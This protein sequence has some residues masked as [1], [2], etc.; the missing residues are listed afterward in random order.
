LIKL[1][2][3]ELRSLRARFPRLPC[4][5]VWQALEKHF[6]LQV[7]NLQRFYHIGDPRDAAFVQ[8]L[9]AGCKIDGI[10]CANDFTAAQLMHSLAKAKI[11]VPDDI[12]L[13]GFD[14]L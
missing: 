13:I 2:Y 8:E 3:D 1:G 7:W 6:S 14:N 12:R 5:L 11:R 10:I 4:R 9:T